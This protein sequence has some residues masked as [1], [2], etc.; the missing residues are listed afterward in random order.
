ML[1]RTPQLSG[2]TIYLQSMHN[3]MNGQKNFFKDNGYSLNGPFTPIRIMPWSSVYRIDTF[4]GTLYLKHMAEPFRIEAKLLSSLT[5][6]FPIKY[7][8]L[9]DIMKTY[10]VS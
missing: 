1:K 10:V 7:L 2:K 3:C 9:L 4:R 5:P 6:Y 8:G